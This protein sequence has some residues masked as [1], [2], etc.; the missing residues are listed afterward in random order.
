[1][2]VALTISDTSEIEQ[3]VMNGDFELGVV[4]SKN[5]ND[6]LIYRELWKDE[7]V[8]AVPI[9]HK[10]AGKKQVPFENLSK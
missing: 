2:T 9:G 3:R 4:G 5:T 8:L 6:S 7:L 1:M 10:W